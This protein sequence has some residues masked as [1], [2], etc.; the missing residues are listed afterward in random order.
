MGFNRDLYITIINGISQLVGGLEHDFYFPFHKWDVILPID[1]LI[2]FRGVE[3]TNQF[4]I[5]RQAIS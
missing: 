1:E 4:E 3:T 2:F 5:G